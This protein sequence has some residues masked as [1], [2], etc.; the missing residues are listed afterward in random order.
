MC[1]L[2]EPYIYIYVYIRSCWVW[3]LRYTTRLLGQPAC[4]KQRSRSSTIGSRA[5]AKLLK[6]S[7]RSP[8]IRF[9]LQGIIGLL[10]MALGVISGRFRVVLMIRREM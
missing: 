10:Y 8:E 2:Y 7:S 6:S 9:P 3:P 4:P 1:C 5:A